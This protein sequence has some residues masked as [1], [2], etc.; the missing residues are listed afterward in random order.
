MPISASPGI[1]RKITLA[2]AAACVVIVAS[3]A[4]VIQFQLNGVDR[5]ARLEARNLAR[6]VAY[7]AL[8]DEHLQQY[9]QGLHELYRRD[10]VIVDAQKRTVA[11]AIPSEV[12]EV[13][14]AVGHLQLHPTVPRT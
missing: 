12:G 14:A 9:V 10:V 11:D 7:S 1:R 13:F 8:D 3:T 2:F 4:V 6:L 5:G